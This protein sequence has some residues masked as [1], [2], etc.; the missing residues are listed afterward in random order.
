MIDSCKISRPLKKIITS[1]YI[2]AIETWKKETDCYMNY[3]SDRVFTVPKG[4]SIAR[5]HYY[6]LSKFFKRPRGVKISEFPESRLNLSTSEKAKLVPEPKKKATKKYLKKKNEDNENKPINESNEAENQEEPKKKV[7]ALKKEPK[8]PKEPKKTKKS[9]KDKENQGENSL[10]FNHD[11]L[12]E[13]AVINNIALNSTNTTIAL[14]ETSPEPVI[15]ETNWR[16]YFEKE[17]EMNRKKQLARY[18]KLFDRFKMNET[19][20]KEKLITF[21]LV[22]K[23]IIEDNKNLYN[24]A[25]LKIS[26]EYLLEKLDDKQSNFDLKYLL[27]SVSRV[28]DW[29]RSDKMHEILL[30]WK[31]DK[32]GVMGLDGFLELQKS[33][34]EEGTQF[35]KFIEKC[36][37]ESDKPCTTEI[38]NYK[39]LEKMIKADF[40]D[41]Q[42][43]E[44]EVTHKHLFYTGKIDCL[45]YYKDTL[46]LIDWKTSD[47]DKPELK[48]L[49]SMPVQLSAY[50][51]AFLND[52]KH[53]ELRK[54]H[55]INNGLIV[56]INKTTGKINV[57]SLN[58]QLAEFYWY[59]WLSNLKKFWYILLKEKMKMSTNNS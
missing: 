48:D 20:L 19:F 46:C 34:L 37:K 36:L 22:S 17:D 44:A 15:K 10:A 47:K 23:E 41:V 29:G 40:K 42:L 51:G 2:N 31:I 1:R 30:K 33:Q 26:G 35:H 3:L 39:E 45:A 5:K 43:I 28:M 24:E 59:K 25:E 58:Y 38:E 56:N 11:G 54:K 57:H 53:D 49:Y 27:P 12:K 50:L 55:S 16:E 13:Y 4:V 21:P 6:I 8:E 9:K 14:D 52:P 18:M 7:N 32:V